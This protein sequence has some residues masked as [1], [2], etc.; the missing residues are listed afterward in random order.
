[1][2]AASQTNRGE[3]RWEKGIREE[4]SSSLAFRSLL[5]DV[6][7]VA[8][9]HKVPR[10]DFFFRSMFSLQFPNR[11]SNNCLNIIFLAFSIEDPPLFPLRGNIS[12]DD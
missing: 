12:P 4:I 10:T 11:A 9:K 2:R 6:T 5:A 1:M 7:A 3:M 8:V